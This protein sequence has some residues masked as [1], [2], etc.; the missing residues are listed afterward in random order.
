VGTGPGHLSAVGTGPPCRMTASTWFDTSTMQ[1]SGD[2]GKPIGSNPGSG[3][4]TGSISSD[5]DP[6]CR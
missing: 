2:N 6:A 4:A 5:S 1:G 3:S